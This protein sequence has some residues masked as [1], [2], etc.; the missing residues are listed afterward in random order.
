MASIIK[1]GH[2]ICLFFAGLLG[3]VMECWLRG[4]VPDVSVVPISMSYNRT[5]EEKLYAYEMLG[6]PKPKE[7]TSVRI[8]IYS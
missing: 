5:L 3:C 4:R 8:K 7:S 1:K 6:V 2:L